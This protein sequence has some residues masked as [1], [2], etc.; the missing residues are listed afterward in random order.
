LW[1]PE[2]TFVKCNFASAMLHYSNFRAARFEEC[3]LD[4]AILIGAYLE[5][6][7][8][9]GCSVDDV[10][11][12]GARMHRESDVQWSPTTD[13]PL[14]SSNAFASSFIYEF[15]QDWRSHWIAGVELLR[16][17]PGDAWARARAGTSCDASASPRCLPG[18]VHPRRCDPPSR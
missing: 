16:L 9:S 5:D 18:A 8:F 6:T 2:V 14:D 15:E 4:R 13:A 3:T 17:D 10:V 11:S 1:V 12:I 7:T